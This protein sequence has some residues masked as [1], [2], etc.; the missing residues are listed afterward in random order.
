MRQSFM[1][2]DTYGHQETLVWDKN[3]DVS[4]MTIWNHQTDKN[5]EKLNLNIDIW[6]NI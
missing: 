3:E 2:L 5:E 4:E 1:L 6:L